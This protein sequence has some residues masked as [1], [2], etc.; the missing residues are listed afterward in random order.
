[1][2]GP[3]A[4]RQLFG[5]TNKLQIFWS[6]Q[7][8]GQQMEVSKIFKV[9]FLFFVRLCGGKDPLLRV[10]WQ[11]CQPSLDPC[12][13]PR[14]T[15]KFIKSDPNTEK[16]FFFRDNSHQKRGS[17]KVRQ[18]SEQTQLQLFLCFFPLHSLA[19]LRCFCAH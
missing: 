4:M 10:S 17:P 1:M 8:N 3:S 11:Q 13:Y 12:P 7:S 18:C 2:I 9:L 5:L 15:H 6:C 16:T 19:N 14:R